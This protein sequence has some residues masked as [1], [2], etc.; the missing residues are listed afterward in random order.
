MAK[1]TTKSFYPVLI[2]LEDGVEAVNARIARMTVSQFAEFERMFLKSANGEAGVPLAVE[3]EDTMTAEELAVARAKARAARLA[4]MTPAERKA[5][6]LEAIARADELVAWL[7]S[8]VTRYVSFPPGQIVIEEEDPEGNA[9]DL[10]IR[11]GA[12]FVR[13]FGARSMLLFDL[14]NRI[15]AVNKMP[16]SLRKKSSSLSDSEPISD[17]PRPDQR[18]TTPGPVAPPVNAGASA[19]PGGATPTPSAA[20]SSSGATTSGSPSRRVRS[21]RTGIRTSSRSSDGSTGATH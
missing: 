14:V 8:A 7:E 15:W 17:V 2:K 3:G 11:T 13:Y 4:A 9:A 12:D 5:E 21:K 19:T 6:D 16:E 10:E 20:A 1:F 18:G